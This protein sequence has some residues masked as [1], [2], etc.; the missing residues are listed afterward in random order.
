MRKILPFLAGLLSG[1]VLFAITT[2]VAM[3]RMMIQERTSKLSV[4]ATVEQIRAAALA[5]GWVVSG[6]K[7]LHESVLKNGGGQLPPVMLV[8]LCQAHH[9]YAILSEGPSRKLATFMPCTIS[10]YRRD[11]GTTAVGSMNAGLLGRMFGGTVARVMGTEVA[12]DQAEILSFLD[13]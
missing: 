4:E 10:V 8:E 7:A 13:K 2:V 6:V 11:D 3:P 9:A 1:I 12:R 5:K